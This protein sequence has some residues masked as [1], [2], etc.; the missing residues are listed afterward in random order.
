M[1]HLSAGMLGEQMTTPRTTKNS[2]LEHGVEGPLTATQPF[3]KL[4][5]KPDLD[6]GPNGLR[7]PRKPSIEVGGE[8]PNLNYRRRGI[9]KG[10]DKL[11]ND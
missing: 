2:K 6:G 4:F 11:K 9:I 3:E 10:Q 7:P 8:A 1:E 5:S